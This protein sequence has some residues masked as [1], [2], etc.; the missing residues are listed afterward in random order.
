MVYYPI[1]ESF[2]NILLIFDIQFRK[3]WAYLLSK[4]TGENISIAY[5][6]L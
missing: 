6:K 4:G 3:A 2:K 5:K 1:G